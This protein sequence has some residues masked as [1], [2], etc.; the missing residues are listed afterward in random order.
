M[1]LLITLVKFDR[2]NKEIGTSLTNYSQNVMP[3]GQNTVLLCSLFLTSN[4]A[5]PRLEYSQL[6]VS[7]MKPNSFTLIDFCY[8][9][10]LSSHNTNSIKSPQVMPKNSKTPQKIVCFVQN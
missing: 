7:S 6:K 8:L 3:L 5:H 9:L 10:A 4:D 1:M 2:C